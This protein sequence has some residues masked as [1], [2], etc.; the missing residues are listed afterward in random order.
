LNAELTPELCVDVADALGLPHPGL[1]EK[2]YHVVRALQALKE[3]E[4]AGA[5]LV[6]GGGTSLCRAHRLIERMS[7]DI[8]LRIA[9]AKPLAD[10]GRRSFRV[11]VSE[12]LIAAGFEFDPRN[13]DHL[14][15]HDGGKTFVYNLLYAQVTTSV[16]SLRPGVKVEISSWPLLRASVQCTVSSFVAQARGAAAEVSGIQ[17]VD[18]TETA[19]DKFVALTRRLGEEQYKQGTRDR[20]LLRH[21]YD[22]FRIRS[23]VALDE[24]RPLIG[25]ILESDRRSR[26]RGFPAY[27]EN[28]QAVSRE[29]VESLAKDPSYAEAFEGFQRDMVYGARVPLHE[30]LPALRELA[31]LL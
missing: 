24:M 17:C 2:D 7:E 13:P 25:T 5:R 4:H 16:A 14:A 8:D 22:L 6:F 29:A 28:P 19:A 20:S 21:V 27:A 12:S 18:V 23:H 30:C 10:G 9:S 11:A 3:V 26:S 15:V 31:T 1:V